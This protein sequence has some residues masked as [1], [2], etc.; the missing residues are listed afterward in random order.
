MYVYNIFLLLA[1]LYLYNICVFSIYVIGVYCI[2]VYVCVWSCIIELY[3][4][5]GLMELQSPK[6]AGNLLNNFTT[7]YLGFSVALFFFCQNAYL[8]GNTYTFY[9]CHASFRSPLALGLFLLI[10]VEK[11]F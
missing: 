1:Y 9:F 7:I 4:F 3:P 10:S 5:S 8:F 11:K 2:C 6:P